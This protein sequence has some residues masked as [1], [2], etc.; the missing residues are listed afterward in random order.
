VQAFD[1]RQDTPQFG[2]GVDGLGAR[3]RRLPANI[4]D[5]CAFRFR[6]PG[7]FRHPVR[8]ASGELNHMRAYSGGL[9]TQPR[10]CVA[11][12]EIIAGGHLGHDQT[13]AELGRKPSDGRVSHPRHRCQED[14]GSDF[15]IA[16]LQWLRA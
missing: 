3:T 2:F 8:L 16:Y 6:D 9:A 10:H 11:V 5:I 12:D 1:D 14:R 7:A 4:D 15:N 13:G